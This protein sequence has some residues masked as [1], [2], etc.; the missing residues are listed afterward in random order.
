MISSRSSFE[1][2][3]EG[4]GCFGDEL[5][6]DTGTLIGE[7]GVDRR[8]TSRPGWREWPGTALGPEGDGV[9]IELFG[10]VACFSPYC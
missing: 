10:A 5:Y 6:V 4:E 9:V 1:R 7:A 2:S 3:V 8:C